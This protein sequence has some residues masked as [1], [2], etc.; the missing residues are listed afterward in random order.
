MNFLSFTAEAD[1][2]HYLVFALCIDGNTLP[3]A[4]GSDEAILPY[5]LI[6]DDLPGLDEQPRSDLDCNRIVAV[7]SCGEFGCGGTWARVAK[8]ADRV[9]LSDFKTNGAVSP[10]RKSVFVFSRANYDDVMS[11]MSDIATQ[12]GRCQSLGG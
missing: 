5:R 9:V 3:E 4:V 2:L 10:I 6:T 1:P 8:S 11:R 7:C 12:C